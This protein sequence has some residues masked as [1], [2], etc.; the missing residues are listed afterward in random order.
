MFLLRVAPGRRYYTALPTKAP[1]PAVKASARSVSD[2][3]LTET[4]SPAAMDMAPATSPATPDSETSVLEAAAEATPRIRTR[5]RND[6]VICAKDGGPKP[7]NAFDEMALCMKAPHPLSELIR[8]RTFVARDH[9]SHE[10]LMMRK[11]CKRHAGNV[12]EDQRKRDV[13]D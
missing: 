10:V 5:R 6:T 9:R 2:C 12:E 8:I 1:I 13:G 3:E 11:A 7:S 4:Y